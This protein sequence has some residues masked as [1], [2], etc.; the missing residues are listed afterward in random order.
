MWKTVAEPPNARDAI[1]AVAVEMTIRLKW[2]SSTLP[3]STISCANI[4]LPIGALN[5]VAMPA[6]APH[7]TSSLRRDSSRSSCATNEPIEP[8][9]CAIGPSRPT[10]GAGA[11]RDGGA[12]R[13]DDHPAPLHAS[14]LEV[15]H[16]EKPR[17]AIAERMSREEALEE[18][19]RDAAGGEHDRR[20]ERL[21]RAPGPEQRGEG[22]E[23][24][25]GGRDRR[26]EDDASGRAEEA[27]QPCQQD[28]AG[29]LRVRRCGSRPRHRV[30]MPKQMHACQSRAA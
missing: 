3:C 24:A 15:H 2:A 16:L 10:D 1:T 4:T 27:D 12:E 14:A 13:L 9:I 26:L 6:A 18:E 22:A 21:G 8:P 7:A 17:E 30:T 23:S 28:E 20:R 25:R 19:Q 5:V 29:V 11:E